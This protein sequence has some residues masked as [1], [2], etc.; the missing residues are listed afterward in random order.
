MASL[1]FIDF[2]EDNH[3]ERAHHLTASQKADEDVLEF[4]V[5]HNEDTTLD[6]SDT[7]EIGEPKNWLEHWTIAE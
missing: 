5:R 4:M 3:V 7:N 6:M 1:D 2:I